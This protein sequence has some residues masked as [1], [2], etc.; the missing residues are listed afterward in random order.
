MYFL[1][2]LPVQIHNLQ[3]AAS[4]GVQYFVSG[5]GGFSTPAA[6]AADAAHG[7]DSGVIHGT[8][9]LPRLLSC[10]EGSLCYP[11][12]TNFVADGPGYLT[13]ALNNSATPHTATATFYAVGR[14]VYSA[15]F[16]A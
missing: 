10:P 5:A 14:V 8:S 13:M 7:A 15:S 12:T 3:H 4:N 9:H 6:A 2:L 11:M 1:P 16:A